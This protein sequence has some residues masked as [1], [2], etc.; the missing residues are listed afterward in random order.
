MS[1]YTLVGCKPFP[2]ELLCH[3]CAWPATEDD[4]REIAASILLNGRRIERRV[5][6]QSRICS[7][8]S[9]DVLNGWRV[10]CEH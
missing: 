10:E 2:L 4:A 6:L 8:M 1:T 9:D 3:A 7:M 5:V